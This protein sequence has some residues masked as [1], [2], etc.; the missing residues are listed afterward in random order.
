MAERRESELA[1]EGVGGLGATEERGGLR[2]ALFGLGLVSLSGAG[3]SGAA[4]VAEDE[5]ATA[6]VSVLHPSLANL[7]AHCVLAVCNLLLQPPTPTPKLPAI[8]L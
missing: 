4:A 3:A 5:E 1:S 8:I 7:P 6:A 2:I